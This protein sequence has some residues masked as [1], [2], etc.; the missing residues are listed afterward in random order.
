MFA[1]GKDV[2]LT[3]GKGR[4]KSAPGRAVWRWWKRRAW[5][6]PGPA[7]RI[8]GRCPDRG[9]VAGFNYSRGRKV[10]VTLYRVAQVRELN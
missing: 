4:P 7:G 6:F 9:E 8:A 2:A 1:L 10:H 5:R 3:D